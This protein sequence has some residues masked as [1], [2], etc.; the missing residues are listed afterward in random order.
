MKNTNTIYTTTIIVSLL[1]MTLAAATLS[2]CRSS[3]ATA[4]QQSADTL[5][6]NPAETG[7]TLVFYFERGE[8]FN[9][10]LM[11]LWLEDTN[12]TYLQTL[13]VAE[14]I[15]KGRYLHGD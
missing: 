14:S 4:L 1:T 6:T 7:P 3:R 5:Y 15:A 2:T 13:F 9:H 11:A 10:P 12:G 8:S